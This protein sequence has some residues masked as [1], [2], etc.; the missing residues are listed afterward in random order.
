[1]QKIFRLQIPLIEGGLYLPYRK[2]TGIIVVLR[3]LARSFFRKCQICLSEILFLHSFLR[4]FIL[5][6]RLSA[7]ISISAF[8][9]N[10]SIS[11]IKSGLASEVLCSVQCSV[12]LKAY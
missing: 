2:T 8:G 9:S 11:C 7:A 4:T 5:F 6:S 10:L 12:H 1:M 3:N